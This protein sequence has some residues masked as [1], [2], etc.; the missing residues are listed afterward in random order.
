MKLRVGLIGAG[1]FGYLHLAGY[2]KNEH[3]ELIAVA[4]KT[5]QS[6]KT[7]SKKFDIPH[8]YWGDDW[9]NMLKNE[10]LD[11][12]SIC[13]PNFYHAKMT[14]EAIRN[15]I[16]ILCEKPIAV[17]SEE[18]NQIED[19]LSKKSI[20]YFSSFQKRYNPLVPR[21]KRII[22]SGILGDINLVRYFFSHYGP[23]TSW[24]PLS[25]Q[26]W[27]FDSKLAGGG[28]LLDLGV[29]AIDLLRH[30]IG[31]YDKVEGFS[32][33]TSCKDIKDEDNCSVL[34]RFK[35]DA[36]GMIT[37]SWC[38]EPFDLIEIFGTK[39]M[40]RVDLSSNDTPYYKP[41]KMSRE[42]LIKELIGS[43]A[44]S[45]IA[46]HA[47]IKHFINC[48]MDK[49]QEKPDFEDGKRAVEFVLE[50]YLKLK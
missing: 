29:H 45:E 50:A 16:N 13:T 46:Q 34:F 21:V 30:L 25:E 27:F 31:E 1:G 41:N 15:G 23:Y 33:N 32:H 12:V 19:E 37:T 17:S 7:A 3:C 35:N 36:I 9:L 44:S 49:N 18:L 47:L 24:K 6:A 26:K 40:L 43:K 48:V 39:G 14:I 5:E 10:Q 42:P 4:S 11:V 38:N 20:I 22:E 28:V 8:F 2:K